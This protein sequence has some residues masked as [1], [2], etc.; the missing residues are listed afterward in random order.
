MSVF[1]SAGRD[2][3]DAHA[4]RELLRELAG[5]VDQRGLRHVVRAD[6]R[7]R[8]AARRPTRRSAPRRRARCMYWCHAARTKRSGAGDV[9]VEHLRDRAEVGVHQRTEHRVDRGVV[10]DD[11]AAAERAR[12]SCATA[13]SATSGSPTEPATVTTRAPSAA[14]AAAVSSSSAGLRATTH[15][16]APAAAR[17][18]GDRPADAAGPAGDEHGLAVEPQR[19]RRDRSQVEPRAALARGATR[20]RARRVRAG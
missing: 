16:S 15:T 4:R 2:R 3:V 5:E 14:S 12:S 9:R 6:E 18:L 17:R 11:V 7:A 10:H 8:A 1:T 19:G 13:A 20:P